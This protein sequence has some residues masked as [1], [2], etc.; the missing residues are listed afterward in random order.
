MEALQNRIF[1]QENGAAQIVK[2]QEALTDQLAELNKLT[3]VCPQA[4]DQFSIL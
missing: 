3:E 2:Q 1:L 4:Q